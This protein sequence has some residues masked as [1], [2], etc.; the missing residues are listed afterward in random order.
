MAKRTL[1]GEALAAALDP[2]TGHRFRDLD[3]LRR[4]LTH[5]SAGPRPAANNERL[6]FLGDRVLGLVVA[7]LLFEHF[8]EAPEG[9]LSLRFKRWSNAETLRRDRRAKSGWTALIRAGASCERRAGRASDVNLRADAVEALIAAIYLDGGL[10]A[11]RGFIL[12]YWETR[13]RT[14]RARAA[15]D[16]KTELQE[17]AHQAR[18]RVAGLC[19]SSGRE[20]P[21]PRAGL[22]GRVTGRRLR[23]GKRRS[24]RSKREAEAG[25]GSAILLREGVWTDE[26]T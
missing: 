1:S 15:R 26:R 22:H 12:R 24:G 14:V 20:G 7:E 16:P 23:A 6:E 11:A 17:W 19:A 3:R 5:A 13:S 21:G 10:E 2:P 9:E 8:P 18:R 4:A 25:G